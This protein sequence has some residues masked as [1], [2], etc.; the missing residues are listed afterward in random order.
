[1]LYGYLK[2]VLSMATLIAP[3]LYAKQVRLERDRQA[4]MWVVQQRSDLQWVMKHPQQSLQMDRTETRHL[5]QL[6]WDLDH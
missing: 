2:I 3:L 6:I 5:R 4:I 1:M